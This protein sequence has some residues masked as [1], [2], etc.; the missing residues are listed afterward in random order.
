MPSFCSDDI[1]SNY[2]VSRGSKLGGLT[3]DIVSESKRDKFTL[4]LIYIYNNTYYYGHH[5]NNSFGGG[6]SSAIFEITEDMINSKIPI[7]FILCATDKSLDSARKDL[8]KQ[9]YGDDI[10]RD[11]KL[12]WK[13]KYIKIATQGGNPERQRKSRRKSRKS[14]QTRRK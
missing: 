7:K 10:P 2:F 12:K 4:T 11:I 14:K 5:Y 8:W 13:D 6:I 1:L 3:I 9:L